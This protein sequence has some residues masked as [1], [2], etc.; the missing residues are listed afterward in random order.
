MAARHSEP[1]LQELKE[2]SRTGETLLMLHDREFFGCNVDYVSLS[3][4]APHRT[5]FLC[6]DGIIASGDSARRYQHPDLFLH[7]IPG[8]SHV[9]ACDTI[10]WV[11]DQGKA[12]QVGFLCSCPGFRDNPH[13]EMHTQTTGMQ[14]YCCDW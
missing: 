11:S 3:A 13:F 12:N 2:A 9:D 4:T 1:L 8:L 10:G 5:M 14:N 7:N 6:M